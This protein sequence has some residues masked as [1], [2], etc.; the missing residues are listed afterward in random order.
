MYS[1]W[2]PDVN[3]EKVRIKMQKDTIF[4]VVRPEGVYVRCDLLLILYIVDYKYN[5]QI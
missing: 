2:E 1:I 3:S 4:I 5:A